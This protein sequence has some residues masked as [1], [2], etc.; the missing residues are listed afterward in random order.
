MRLRLMRLVVLVIKQL[1]CLNLILTFGLNKKGFGKIIALSTFILRTVNLLKNLPILGNVAEE[2]KVI[3]KSVTG[4]I[5]KVLSKS[6]KI[7][8]FCQKPEI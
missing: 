3:G 1:I 5:I 4:K 7:S 6:R 2:D 8:K